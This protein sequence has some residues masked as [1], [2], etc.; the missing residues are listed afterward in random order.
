MGCS[1]ESTCLTQ[2]LMLDEASA[3][4]T[5]STKKELACPMASAVSQN[6]KWHFLRW[7]YIRFY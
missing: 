4:C 1:L 5:Y 6:V 3:G 2:I 7:G